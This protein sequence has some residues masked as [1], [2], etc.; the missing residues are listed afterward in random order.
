MP[1]TIVHNDI[2][3]MRADAIVVPSDPEPVRKDGI[4]FLIYEAADPALWEARQQI[5]RIRPGCCAMTPAF[6]LDAKY[7]IHAV[8]PQEN[9]DSACQSALLRNCYDRALELCAAL[10][11]SSAAI[12]LLPGGPKDQVLDVALAAFRSFLQ[13]HDMQLYLVV[14]DRRSLLL[15]EPLQQRILR[16]VDANYSAFQ[17]QTHCDIQTNY[18]IK[19]PSRKAR[20]HSLSLPDQPEAPYA[21]SH[22]RPSSFGQAAPDA[23]PALSFMQDAS[24]E[25]SLTE[26]LRHTDAGFSETLLKLIDAS[27]KTD[28]EVYHKAN[29]TRQHFSKIRSNP[30]YKPSKPTAL[31]LAVALELDLAQTKDLIARAGYA[32]TN[33][34]EFDVI[35]SFFI[36]QKLYDLF[37]INSFLFKYD[38]PLLGAS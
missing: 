17:I 23:A 19:Y 11:C 7:V 38:Q 5:G 33:A 2:S 15:P 21:S 34:S 31:A 18:N 22:P 29:L 10:D 24:F 16:Y 3:R 35:V 30:G 9:S 37:L 32:L 27:G 25:D 1:F 14:R 28:A 20:R 6:G 4:D 13:T 12:A 36:L 26:L 8:G